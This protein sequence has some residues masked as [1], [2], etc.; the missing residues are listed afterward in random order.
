ML[1]SSEHSTRF[2]V[3]FFDLYFFTSQ[4]GIMKWQ[5]GSVST[6]DA[7]KGKPRLKGTRIRVSLILGYFAD[8]SRRKS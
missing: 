1:R 5:E 8:G 7:L 3:Y 2:K 6:P 4:N